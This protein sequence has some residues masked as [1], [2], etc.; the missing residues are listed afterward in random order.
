[1]RKTGAPISRSSPMS[2]MHSR[3]LAAGQGNRLFFTMP[4]CGAEVKTHIWKEPTEH[5]QSSTIMA[6]AWLQCELIAA[7]NRALPP[8]F[9]TS[10]K[11]C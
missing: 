2:A 3:L 11:A 7:L 8:A 1:M 5:Q 10:A 9:S 4:P 6:A